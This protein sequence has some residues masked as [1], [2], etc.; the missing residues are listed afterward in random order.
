MDQPCPVAM[1]HI[2]ERQVCDK[3]DKKAYGEEQHEQGGL[4]TAV[5]PS[6]EEAQNDSQTDCQPDV[7]PTDEVILEVVFEFAVAL[8]RKELEGEDHYNQEHYRQVE[9]DRTPSDQGAFLFRSIL[10]VDAG[11]KGQVEGVEDNQSEQ[12]LLQEERAGV[13]AFG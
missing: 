5:V 4:R 12:P 1:Q 10:P 7:Q 8:T 3:V 9:D 6:D 11:R 2:P 13:L